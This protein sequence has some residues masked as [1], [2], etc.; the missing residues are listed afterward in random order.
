MVSPF[1][2]FC[3]TNIQELENLNGDVLMESMFVTSSTFLDVNNFHIEVFMQIIT[4]NI[5]PQ[6]KYFILETLYVSIALTTPQLY[7]TTPQQVLGLSDEA[8]AYYTPPIELNVVY[9]ITSTFF[10][11]SAHVLHIF[12]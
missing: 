3:A 9:P 12:S 11:F 6:C 10:C 2:I 4:A 7:I 5:H 1:L 8:R